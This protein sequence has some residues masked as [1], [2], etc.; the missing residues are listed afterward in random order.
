VDALELIPAYS[1]VVAFWEALRLDRDDELDRVCDP[2]LIRLHGVGPG[3]ASRLRHHLELAAEEAVGTSL[4]ARVL[5]HGCVA[6]GSVRLR[7]SLSDIGNTEGP[8][9]FRTW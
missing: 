4:T 8:E 1:V 2:T 5:D 9:P 7:D 6:F 3:R